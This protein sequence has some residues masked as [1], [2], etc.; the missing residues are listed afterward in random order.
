MSNSRA[1]SAL[2]DSKASHAAE[3]QR[4]ELLDALCHAMRSANDLEDGR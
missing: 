1:T 2:L 3:Q 4:I